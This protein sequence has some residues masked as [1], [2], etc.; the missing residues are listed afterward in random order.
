MASLGEDADAQPQHLAT[1]VKVFS[2]S[3]SLVLCHSLTLLLVASPYWAHN[4]A[5][6]ALLFCFTV[7]VCECVYVCASFL[8]CQVYVYGC[9]IDD[10]PA[11][12]RPT[13]DDQS[14]I[15]RKPQINIKK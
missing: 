10:D 5:K 3:V 6:I 11:T 9:C 8:C 7:S 4:G 15:K 13:I 12:D 1:Y 2:L 14:A